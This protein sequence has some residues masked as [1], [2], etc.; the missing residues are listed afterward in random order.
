MEK[1]QNKVSNNIY[2]YEPF[3]YEGQVTTV[4]VDLR[5]GIPAVDIIGIADSNVNA[6]RE[7]LK[8]AT[9][10]AGFEFPDGRVL[11]SVSPADLRKNSRNADLAMALS[12]Q[13]ALN[14][15]TEDK[16]LAVG[17]LDSWDSSANVIPAKAMRAAAK[18]I[19]DCF[20]NAGTQASV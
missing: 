16:I 15:T 6:A 14:T 1:F 19:P 17:E 2:S 3:G 11:I 18:D 4:E 7:T 10:N 9:K 20:L 5:H 8:A 13:N 12:V